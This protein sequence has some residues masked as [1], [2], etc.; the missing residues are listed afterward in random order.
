MAKSIKNKQYSEFWEDD[1]LNVQKTEKEIVENVSSEEIKKLEKKLTKKVSGLEKEIKE[2]KE[3]PNEEIEPVNK[4]RGWHAKNEFIDDVGNKFSKGKYIGK[5][6]LPDEEAMY[7]KKAKENIKKIDPEKYKKAVEN[8]IPD[9]P[10]PERKMEIIE[11]PI[12]PPKVKDLSPKKVEDEL[13]IEPQI[14]KIV[15][16]KDI[17][18]QYINNSIPFKMFH[19]G[20]LI[21]DSK[22]QIKKNYPQFNDDGFILFGK[23]YIYRGIRIEKHEKL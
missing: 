7:L 20:N 13:Q 2:L 3:E 1:K 19:R 10:T 17:Y 18:Q 22:V 12:N 14:T 16:D 21:F 4:P 9:F 8:I 5:K 23:N 11:K 15:S 6:E